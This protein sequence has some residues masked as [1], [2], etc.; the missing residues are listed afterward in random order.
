[1]HIALFFLLLKFLE[2]LDFPSPQVSQLVIQNEA[3]DQGDIE[4]FPADP[5]AT[6][7]E[8]KQSVD[9]LVTAANRMTA[10][11]SDEVIVFLNIQRLT[12]NVA[13]HFFSTRN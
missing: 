6:A 8:V 11:T 7:T 12:R 5:V 2:F 1:M 3:Y 9:H 4:A 13:S 10:E